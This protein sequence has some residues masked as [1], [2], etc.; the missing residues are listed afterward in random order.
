MY[1]GVF[2]W[3]TIALRTDKG[4]NR[5]VSSSENG[6]SIP[7]VPVALQSTS[8]ETITDHTEIIL[9]VPDDAKMRILAFWGNE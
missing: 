7:G 3:N 4:I 9:K 5:T 8:P 2:Y 1:G 6:T